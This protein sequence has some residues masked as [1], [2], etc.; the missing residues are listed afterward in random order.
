[1]ADTKLS[2]LTELAATPAVGDELYIRDI[3]EAA[4]AESKR[5]TVANLMAAAGGG[6]ATLTVAETEVFNGAAP[7]SWTDLNLSGTIGAQATLVF[8]KIFAQGYDSK[9]AARRNGDTDELFSGAFMYGAH[10]INMSANT[11][12]ILVAVTDTSGIIEWKFTG[13]FEGV[14]VD[15]IAYIK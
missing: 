11:Y 14:T 10:S 9:A 12:G 2:A 4:A 7:N 15:V 8:L 5:I 13:A 3:S 1:M 6:G